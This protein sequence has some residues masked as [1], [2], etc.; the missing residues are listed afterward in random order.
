MFRG[1]F[2]VPLAWLRKW[3][4]GFAYLRDGPYGAL[5]AEGPGGQLRITLDFYRRNL[6]DDLTEKDSEPGL[7]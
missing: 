1:I 7:P 4:G 6:M 5:R 3:R 2:A